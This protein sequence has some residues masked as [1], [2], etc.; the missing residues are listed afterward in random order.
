MESKKK[1]SAKMDVDRPV[2]IFDAVILPLLIDTKSDRL[3][4]S[5]NSLH[6]L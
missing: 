6:R 1:K 4:R 2:S 3:D 5:N